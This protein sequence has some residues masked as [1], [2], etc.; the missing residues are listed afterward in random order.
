MVKFMLKNDDYGSLI[1][2]GEY[3]N[4]DRN[5]KWKEYNDKLE[6]ES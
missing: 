4:E 2:E 1:F 3:I 5:G 6:F